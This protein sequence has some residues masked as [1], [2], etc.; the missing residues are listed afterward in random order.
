MNTKL[1]QKE[2]WYQPYKN[3]LTFKTKIRIQLWIIIEILFYKYTPHGFSKLRVLILRL[4][5]AKI[6]KGCFIS[7][8]A[9]ILMPWNLEIG[10]FSAID[11]HV[12]IKNK[13][14]VTIQDY[15]SIA[16]YVLIFPGGHKV[17]TRSFEYDYT[18]LTIKNGAFIGAACLIV[19]GVIIGEMCVIGAR[20]V[21]LKDMPENTICYGHPCKP[22][23]ERLD[24]EIFEKYRYSYQ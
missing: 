22:M 7:S 19:K 24:K 6:G 16:E 3:P 5:G 14:K 10:N 9:H 17:K 1:E 18:P 20:S 4:F 12:Y 2:L 21:V 15:V 11:N 13:N 23:T 8:K